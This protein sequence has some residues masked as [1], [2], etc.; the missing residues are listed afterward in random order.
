MKTAIKKREGETMASSHLS[1]SL[2]KFATKHAGAFCFVLQFVSF[3]AADKMI[4][5]SS[6]RPKKAT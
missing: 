6:A 2:L 4:D 1:L 5:A 3:S